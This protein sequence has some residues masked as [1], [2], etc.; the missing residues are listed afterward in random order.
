MHAR[1]L[2]TPLSR[3]RLISVEFPIV[4]ALGMAVLVSACL[5][6]R[7]SAAA[8]KQS[9]AQTGKSP[10]A[11]RAGKPKRPIT[12]SKQTTCLVEP[13]DRDGYVDY[14]AALNQLDR[15]GVTP[16][17][18]AGILL[19][20][21][22]GLS[23]FTSEERTR[24]Y[25]L[26]GIEPLPERG[27]Y[28]TD[29]GNFV[30][31]KLRLQ[32]TKKEDADFDRSMHEPW[33][34]G[35][36]PLVADWLKAN[37]KPL[38]LVVA[39]TRRTGCYL[40]LI[41]TKEPG[42]VGIQFPCLQGSRNAARL[43]VA[44]AMLQIGAGK[45]AE[46]EEDLLACHRL[47]RLCERTPFMIPA[48]VAIAIDSIAC[49]GDVQLM[50]SGRLSAADALAYQ[51]QLRQL[52]PLPSMA[53]V[54]G[55]SER[56]EFLD[57][58]SQ[59]ARERVAPADA[60]G[61][62][63]SFFSK[64]VEKAFSH[65]SAINWDDAL[66]FGN[67]QFDKAVAAAR[68]PTVPQRNKAFEQLDRELSKMA[69]EL[70]DPKKFTA[71]FVAAVAHRDLG[72]LMGKMLTVMLMPAVQGAFDAENRAHTRGIL[73]RLGFALA[74]YHADHDG[75]PDSLNALEPK[76][77][78]RIPHDLFTDGP[79]HYRREGTGCLLYSVGANGVDDGG[80][81]FQSQPRGDDMVLRLADKRRLKK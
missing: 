47:G 43:L 77:I 24:F 7:Q 55:T 48:L 13:L 10:P 19:V 59:L 52:A 37:E 79:L 76:Y 26:L 1:R 63:G 41:E 27:P 11:E 20:R 4:V 78:S 6:Q 60:L 71:S 62:L 21:A 2:V 38:D 31:K 16:E 67:Q 72:R 14:L 54:I 51:Q 33:S 25:Q 39:A 15:Q 9:P 64:P 40:P 50:E 74:A 29:F 42:L 73:G 49:Q 81:T 69:S 3:R 36:L 12:I 44:R 17:N 22:I 58:V 8:D 68:R 30:V 28:V 45:I 46:A 70:K 35:D 80:R 23:D 32:W 75:Y 57:T 61:L 66:V 5:I 18:N 65:R 53:N 56:Y 34:R